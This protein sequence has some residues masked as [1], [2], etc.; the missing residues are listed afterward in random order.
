[1][2]RSHL[3]VTIAVVASDAQAIAVQSDIQKGNVQSLQRQLRESAALATSRSVD[4]CG[5][6][7]TMSLSVADWPGH[8]ATMSE[9]S[10]SR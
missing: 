8:S 6:S 3:I 4:R 10:V 1:M 2:Q 9:I 7:L 5:V